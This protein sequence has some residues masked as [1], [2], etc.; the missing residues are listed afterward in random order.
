LAVTIYQGN[1]D[2]NYKLRNLAS[3]ER[4]IYTPYARA[5]E[6]LL[7]IADKIFSGEILEIKCSLRRV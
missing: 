7:Y 4:D 3:T 2:G 6:I 5:A 1:H